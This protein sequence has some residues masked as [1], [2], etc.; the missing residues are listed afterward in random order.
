MA[1]RIKC[2]MANAFGY[3]DVDMIYN[4]VFRP[5]LNELNIQPLSIDR[6]EY[7]DDIDDKI[8]LAYIVAKK[9]R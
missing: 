7:N 8:S 5:T 9:F 2:F 6:V 4:K 1:K 3:D